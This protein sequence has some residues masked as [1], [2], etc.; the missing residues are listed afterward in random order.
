MD[1]AYGVP[2]PPALDGELAEGLRQYAADVLA[3][4]RE[5]MCAYM[6]ERHEECKDRHDYY[7][8][9]MLELFGEPQ[10]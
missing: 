5:L 9:I 1:N 8:V 10:G 4:Q 7:R 2:I 3:T 6:M